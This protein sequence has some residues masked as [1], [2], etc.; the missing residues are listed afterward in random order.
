MIEA[1]RA[2]EDAVAASPGQAQLELRDLSKSYGDACVVDGVTLEIRS[3]EFV[4]LL[5]SSGSGKTT[6]LMMAAGFTPPTSG[7]IAMDGVDVTGRPAH[8]RGVGMVFQNHALFPHMTAA[9]NVEYPLRMRRVDRRERRARVDEVLETVG[10]RGLGARHPREL[11]GGQQQRVALARALVFRPRVLLMDEPLSAL[12]KRLRDQMQEEL[13]QLHTGLG[14][15]VLYVTHD[16]EEALILSDRIAVMH[17]GRIQQIGSPREIYECPRSAFVAGF[18][19]ESNFLAGTVAE[20]RGGGP[21][22]VRL[23]AGVTVVADAPEA[24]A[25]GARVVVAVRPERLTFDTGPADGHN[26][27]PAV[28]HDANYV[29]G[30]VLHRFEAAGGASVTVKSAPGASPP[31][32]VGGPYVLR[33]A[34]GDGIALTATDAHDDEETTHDDRDG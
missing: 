20:A 5:G 4:T 30:F 2:P 14:V 16:Q 6:T 27:L 7:V 34:T 28:L 26:A 23:D 13:R 33:W 15:T 17:D 3:G 11:S 21:V 31:A 1:T 8:K 9:A 29:G 32:E 18:I 10:L 22:T 19:G 24:F 12:D 25:A